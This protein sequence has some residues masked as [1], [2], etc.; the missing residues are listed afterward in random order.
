[1]LLNQHIKTTP[2]WTFFVDSV[3]ALYH[4]P[5]GCVCVR[6][7][8][9]LCVGEAHSLAYKYVLLFINPTEQQFSPSST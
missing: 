5:M 9:P 8:G 2:L 7:D 6:Q 3:R 1:M 4:E